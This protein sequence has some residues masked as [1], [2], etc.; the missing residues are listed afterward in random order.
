MGN[1]R[2]NRYNPANRHDNCVACV[3]ACLKDRVKGEFTTAD[4]LDMEYNITQRLKGSRSQKVVHEEAI[5][6]IVKATGLYT[7]RSPLG[8]LHCDPR[9]PKTLSPGH[10][11]VFIFGGSSGSGLVYQ[12]SM[13]TFH[14]IYGFI[15]DGGERASRSMRELYDPQSDAERTIGH[16]IPPCYAT[17]FVKKEEA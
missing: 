1:G 17:R 6:L 14:V 15:P 4:K 5:D 3:A 9:E 12:P 16:L 11:A 13:T 8:R 2:P 7:A 10:Y